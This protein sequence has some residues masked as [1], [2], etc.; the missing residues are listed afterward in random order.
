MAPKRTAADAEIA[1]ALADIPSA[2]TSSI[3]T[4]GKFNPHNAGLKNTQTISET[5]AVPDAPTDCFQGMTF[6]FSGI[7]PSIPRA[8]LESYFTEHGGKLT[9]SISGKTTCLVVGTDDVGPS[10]LQKASDLGVKVLDEDGFV[11]LVEKLAGG[12]SKRIKSEPKTEAPAKT[13]SETTKKRALDQGSGKSATEVLAAIPDA[14][15]S[16][17]S[18]SSGFKPGKSN[19]GPAGADRELP[20]AQPNCLAGMTFVFSG[21]FPS[22][23]RSV[24]ENF[25][26]SHGGKVTKAISGKTSCFVIGTEDVG[27]SKIQKAKDL[28]LKTIDEDG[29]IQLIE[30]MPADG[31]SGKQAQAAVKKAKLEAAK[32]EQAAKE[33]KQVKSEGEKETDLWTTK[34]APKKLDDICGNPGLVKRLATWLK[35]WPSNREKGFKPGNSEGSEFR[36]AMLHGP[37]GIGKTTAAHLVAELAGYDVIE[38]NASDTRSKKLLHDTVRGTLSNTS[39]LGFEKKQQKP[40]CIIMDEVDG[41]S[42]GDRGGVGEM[43]KFARTSNV[44]LILI[45]N[46]RTLPKMRPFDKVVFEFAFRRP[47]AGAIRRRLQSIAAAEGL[48]IDTPAIDQL[49]AL[50][51]S[52]IRQMLNMLSTYST[53]EH[54]MSAEQGQKFSKTW[55]KDT[56]LKP[57][58][59]VQKYLT[60]MTWRDPSIDQKLE[61][62]FNDYAF[63]PLMV[64]ENYLNTVPRN[65]HH[66]TQVMKA[67]DSIAEADLVDRFIHGSEQQWGLMPLH[68]LM[69]CVRPSFFV[70]GQI[71]G[72]LAFSAWLGQNSK[73]GKYRRLLAE[74]ES[75][76]RLRIW[77]GAR[78]LRLSYA[79]DFNELLLKPLK[80]RGADGIAQVMEVMDEYY[81]TREDFDVFMELGVGPHTPEQEYKKIPTAVKTAFTRKYNTSA[82]PVPFMKSAAAKSAAA[83]KE[84]VPDLDDVVNDD[85]QDEPE[86]EVE[87]LTTE[88]ENDKYI[89]QKK[90]PAKKGTKKAPAKKA[91]AKKSAPKKAAAKK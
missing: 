59:I 70:A 36:A 48:K 58:D 7:F 67:A 1:S 86:P 22:V 10:K 79:M 65:G 23:D 18:T 57:F 73:G 2:D 44:P 46:E 14:D 56:A 32:V 54:S 31:G 3:G 27:P 71:K 41:M 68:A 75:H 30:S 81:L 38:Y 13:P 20:A 16:T 47:D 42:A 26:T 5:R 29:F 82:H 60:G 33:L 89:K 45:C 11:A 4:A 12:S 78:D 87:S 52:D 35:N 53:S 63:A 77:A 28:K 51:R 9:K 50:T 24:L 62:Y 21:V 83:P 19:D 25:V 17:V 43:A 37:P 66:L 76:V 72:M 84:P 15:T 6:V 34:Y 88:V 85:M 64:Q 8:T 49:V 74:L 80:E 55:Q 90:A 39:L 61:L 40:V 91:P 69:S